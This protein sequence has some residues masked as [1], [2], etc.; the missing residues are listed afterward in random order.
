MKRSYAAAGKKARFGD[1]R[2]GATSADAELNI[3]L[4]ALRDRARQLRRDNPYG[5]RYFTLRA[6]NV[7]GSTG[8]QLSCQ[9]KTARGKL[10]TSANRRIEDAW[11]RW[12]R[13]P[14]ADGKMNMKDALELIDAARACDGDV[15]IEIVRGKSYNDTIAFAIHEADMVDE[16]KNETNALG[17]EIRMGV[18]IDA[19]GRPVAYHF[20]T[21]HRGDSSWAVRKGRGTRRVPAE[22]IIHF[23]KRNRP[24]QT[25]GEPE[26]VA[27]MIT[28][29]MLDGYAEAE[30]TGRRVRSTVGGYFERDLVSPEGG[31][32]P[33]ADDVADDGEFEIEME[34]GQQRALPPG[35]KFKQVDP[36]V[37]GEEYASFKKAELRSVASGLGVSYVSLANDLEGVNFSSIRH[38]LL[39]ERERWKNE[40]QFLIDHVV[41]PIF[42]RWLM[43]WMDFGT[44]ALPISKFDKFAE[45]AQFIGRRWTWVDPTKDV[46]AIVQELKYGLTS[47]SKVARERG[48]DYEELTDEIAADAE[49][50][51]SKG[52]KLHVGKDSGPDKAAGKNGD[53][54]NPGDKPGRSDG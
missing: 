22:N 15:F 17:N 18:E 36:N 7:I 44:Q 41:Y 54:R 31:V 30:V 8:V 39:E 21:Y 24:G 23:Y 2:I 19:Y 38:G 11:R 20:L 37:G 6:D 1:W 53:D 34:P 40:Q 33:L 49:L 45:A 25:R 5:R 10:D 35:Y 47:P 26:T 50:L 14:T 9:A 27:A 13:Q 12:C 46:N 28:L 16:T 32:G 3:A 52:I 48:I 4:G 43:C 42:K 29:K 51:E